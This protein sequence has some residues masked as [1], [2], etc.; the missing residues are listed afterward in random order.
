MVEF[1]NRL[2]ELARDSGDAF[3]QQ[4]LRDFPDDEVG[5]GA[6]FDAGEIV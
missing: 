5:D 1:F 3:F 6:E 2:L 4:M